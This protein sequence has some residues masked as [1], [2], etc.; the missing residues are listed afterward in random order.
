MS[1]GVRVIESIVI[2]GGT[3]EGRRL[4]EKLAHLDV[5]LYVCVATEYGA[6]LMDEHDNVTVICRRMNQPEMEA[7]LRETKAGLC[8][9]ATHPYAVLVSENIIKACDTLGLECIRVVRACE[10]N[11]DE[12]FGCVESVSQAV[13]YL[14]S[15]KGNI[16]ITTGSKE[17]EA[18][19]DIPD[20]K[21]RC[22]A[23]VLPSAEVMNKCAEL[24]FE[25]KKIIGMQG[26]FSEEMNYQM[27]L[28]AKARWVVTKNSGKEGGFQDKCEAAIRAGAGLVI[29]GRPRE[30]SDKRMSFDEAVRYISAFITDKITKQQEIMSQNKLISQSKIMKQNNIHTIYIIGIG[31]GADDE[32]TLA[33]R[34]A[35]DSCDA[36]AGA[37]RCLKLCGDCK[38]KE[39]LST[40]KTDEIIE[41]INKHPEYQS[42]G[43]VYSGDIG[44]YSG[45]RSL[46]AYFEQEIFWE[47]LDGVVYSR[48]PNGEYYG[49]EYVPGLSSPV[50][51]L[52]KLGLSWESVVFTSN[53]GRDNDI[54]SLIRSN[55]NVCTLLGKPNDVSEICR[56]LVDCGMKDVFV[57]VGERLSYDDEELT[58]GNAEDLTDRE[59]DSLS[60]ALFENNHPTRRIVTPGIGDDE[61]IRGSV[62]MTKEEIRIL[63]L[64][65]LRLTEASVLY[66][67]G[68]G[69]GSVSVEAARLMNKGRVYAIEKN[70]EGIQLIKQNCNKHGADNVKVIEGAAPMALEALETPT[71]AFIGGSG[72]KLSEIVGAL[73]GKNE[74]IRCVINAVT[75]ETV[76]ELERLCT[77]YPQCED[78]EIIQVN[79]SRGRRAGGYHLMSAE[80]PVY[81]A[82]FGGE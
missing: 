2:F 28:E 44:F 52:D 70:I 8:V 6:A 30:L 7:F 41:F 43:I 36:L 80:N 37:E 56:K 69:T 77:R 18:Y 46:V 20:Y 24:G 15:V 71:H 42:I 76:A 73:L 27:F 3:T 17:L 19:T 72:G 78:M 21:D 51:M 31:P 62:P 40:Y 4:V 57:T 68:A 54:I 55:E 32:L 60:V 58:M 10:D 5:R 75:I 59:F 82:S 33:A 14:K 34:R 45:A 38:A 74:K 50:Y 9:D 39:R 1:Y 53:H 12:A 25:G 23:R 49:L 79:V 22:T 48:L 67:V 29:I 81:I 65:K 61:F 11:K 64:A 66:D 63:S 26:P 13:E 35:I 47:E 16:F